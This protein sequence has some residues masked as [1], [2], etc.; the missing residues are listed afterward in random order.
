VHLIFIK[1]NDNRTLNM[2]DFNAMV[3][4]CCLIKLSFVEG[5][6]PAPISLIMM[7]YLHQ[8]NFSKA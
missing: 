6:V 4:I 3:L 8:A 2:M 5:A 1:T 7:L